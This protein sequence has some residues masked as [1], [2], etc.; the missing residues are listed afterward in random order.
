VPIC[1]IHVEGGPAVRAADSEEDRFRRE[2]DGL[3]L[4]RPLLSPSCPLPNCDCPRTFPL[5]DCDCP[6]LFGVDLRPRLGIDLLLSRLGLG[7]EETT[8]AAGLPG[9]GMVEARCSDG[10]GEGESWYGD[11]LCP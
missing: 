4:D 5:P 1:G 2:G 7:E 9:E 8:G 10:S 11:P 6:R 3:E